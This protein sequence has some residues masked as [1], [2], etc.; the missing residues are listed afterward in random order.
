MRRLRHSPAC[1]RCEHGNGDLIAV[2]R[3][4]RYAP[5][6]QEALYPLAAKFPPVSDFFVDPALRDDS[7]LKAR[8]EQPAAE[9]TGVFHHDNEP[10]SR[11][12]L[13]ALCARILHARSRLAAGDGAAWRQRQR[14][15]FPLELAARCAQL[16]RHPD[17]ADRDGADLGADG[18]GHRHAEPDAHARD[19]ARPIQCRC[20]AHADDRLERRRHVLLGQRARS[21]LA[22]HASGAG[23]R[24]LSSADGGNRR[25]RAAARACRSFSCTAGS[26]GCFRCRSRA[27]P[28]ICCRPPAPT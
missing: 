27:R 19:G 23:R 6:A 3:A 26:T 12:G 20:E 4:L 1:A 8:L 28:A 25:R 17:R 9:D 11:G 13:L 7:G 21:R 22:V 18:R 10:G 16:W 14:T 24:H 5:R 2:F 15:Q